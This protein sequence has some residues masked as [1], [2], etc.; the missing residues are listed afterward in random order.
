MKVPRVVSA[1]LVALGAGAAIAL[2]LRLRG[3]G[4][5]VRR[6]AAPEGAPR[7]VPARALRRVLEEDA[8][9]LRRRSEG[10]VGRRDVAVERME[11]APADPPT[12][13]A[14]TAANATLDAKPLVP[15]A[16]PGTG[17]EGVR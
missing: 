2:L 3:D 6:D 4:T 13:D 14:D 8:R 1:A 15:L 11:V 12:E 7:P 5:S 16:R 10:E 17:H 9:W